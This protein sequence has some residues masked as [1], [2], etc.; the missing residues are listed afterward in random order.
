MP[1]LDRFLV[2]VVAIAASSHAASAGECAPRRLSPRIVTA[3][4]A[5][6]PPGGGLLV[7][8]GMNEGPVTAES[9][10]IKTWR[11]VDGKRRSA[12]KQRTIAPGLYVLDVVGSRL[13][14]S[15]GGTIRTFTKGTAAPAALPAPSAK[16]IEEA[17][18]RAGN[19]IQT[20]VTVTLAKAPTTDLFLVVRDKDG[21]VARSFA[22]VKAGETTAIIYTAGECTVLP[23]GTQ[24]IQAGDKLTLA[25]VD[26]TGIA[27][28]S[29]A[30]ITVAGKGEGDRAL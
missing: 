8:E 10:A 19:R 13:D 29:S 7:A 1:N 26:A 2:A 18:V 21:K 15:V 6:I 30:A 27:S 16:S 28:P 23:D 3:N 20:Y 11:F 5:T 17:R 22:A 14:N 12:P 25:W 24:V 4:K 9:G